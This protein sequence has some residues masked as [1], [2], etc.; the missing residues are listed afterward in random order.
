MEIYEK[1]SEYFKE[2]GLSQVAIAEE[3]GVTKAYVNALLSGRQRFGKQQ[4]QKWSE[5][6]G[7]SKSWLLTGEGEMLKGSEVSEPSVSLPD[8]LRGDVIPLLPVE[9]VAGGLQLWSRSVEL[10]DCEKVISPVPGA[11]FAIRVSG[12]SMEP[13]IHNGTYIYIKRINDRAFIPWGN[14][15]VI[16]TENGVVVK[17]LFPVADDED[18]VLARSVNREYPPFKIP[19][20]SIFGIYRVLGGSFFVSTI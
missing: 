1:L 7:I 20:A 10:A 3:L 18:C 5:K 16:D 17:K 13:E 8:S 2:R 4:A 19:T 9:A 14:T 11:D 6:F 15:M 12:D